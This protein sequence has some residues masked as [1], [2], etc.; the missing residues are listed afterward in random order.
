MVE[1]AMESCAFKAALACV[2][3]AEGVAEGAGG[4]WRDGVLR[5]RGGDRGGLG[6]VWT[7]LHRER[8][9]WGEAAAQGAPRLIFLPLSLLQGLSQAP[10]TD[11]YLFACL[12]KTGA[13]SLPS[14]PA[15]SSRGCSVKKKAICALTL[16]LSHRSVDR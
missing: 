2:G 12:A 16:L 1:R 7:P 8:G 13:H 11:L 15:G 10:W 14:A 9:R 5:W 6:A 4:G 3:G